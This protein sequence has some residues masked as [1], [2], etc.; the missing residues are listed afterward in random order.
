MF[1]NSRLTTEIPLLISYRKLHEEFSA[2]LP[3]CQTT[4]NTYGLPA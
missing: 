1:N 4:A 3:I 2:M